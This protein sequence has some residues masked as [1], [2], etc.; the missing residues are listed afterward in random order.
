LPTGRRHY[1]LTLDDVL[2][3]HDA[4][5]LD[6]G[7]SGVRD[8]AAIARPYSGY[9]RAIESK[10]AALV[11]SLALNHGFIDA[12]KRTAL[13]ACD[14]LL[15]KSGYRLR[16]DDMPEGNDDMEDMILAVVE[17]HM[18]FD[19]LTAW[20]KARIVRAESR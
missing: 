1:R 15:A 2:N 7:L 6:G 19:E 5:L 11:H 12:N 13:F 18:N 9:Y 4:A 10:A 8:R 16:R 20:F 14:L 17:H 3:L